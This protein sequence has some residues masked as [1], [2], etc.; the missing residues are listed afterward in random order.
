VNKRAN[1]TVIGTFVVAAIGLAVVSIVV[2]SSGQLFR[3]TFTVVSLFDGSVQGLQLGAPVTF[4]GVQIGTVKDVR[5]GLPNDP[6]FVQPGNTDVRVPVIYEFDNALLVARGGNQELTEERLG[7]L[8]AA[9]LKAQLNTESFVTGRLLISLDFYP[10]QPGGADDVDWGYPQIPTVATPI[11]EIQHQI[12]G[13]FDKMED[14]DL[15]AVIDATEQT[16]LAITDFVEDPEVRE[17]TESLDETLANLDVT[18]ASF[19]GVAEEIS[20]NV[21]SVSQSAEQR[22]EQLETVLAETENTLISLQNALDPESPLTIQLG[23]TLAEFGR[24]ARAF[25][26]LAEALEQ[27]PSAVIRGREVPNNRPEGN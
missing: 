7:E 21:T 8:V 23:L 4:R 10:D 22:A 2:L 17:L 25:A 13:L 6:R 15:Q 12:A 20:A 16:L 14:L 9:G 1:M 11:E 3:D 27:N 26:A 5:I 24:A 18:M 19:R